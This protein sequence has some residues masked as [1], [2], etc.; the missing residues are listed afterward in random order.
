MPCL[1]VL[2]YVIRNIVS[3]VLIIVPYLWHA[4]LLTMIFMTDIVYLSVIISNISIYVIFVQFLGGAYCFF[5]YA[6]SS[7]Q[8]K[9]ISLCNVQYLK[10]ELFI[11][12]GRNPL[13]RNLT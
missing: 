10:V 2:A 9:K 7:I 3:V 13:H 8:L 4:I 12:R 11:T 1:N 5:V 6:D